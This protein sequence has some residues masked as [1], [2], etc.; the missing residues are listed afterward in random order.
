MYSGAQKCLSSPPGLSPLSFGERAME[1]LRTRDTKVASFY[2]DMLEVGKYWGSERKYHHTGSIN[3]VYA[4]REGLRV[5]HE[6]GLQ[7][8]WWDASCAA[9]FLSLFP[10]LKKSSLPFPVFLGAGIAMLPWQRLC[11]M[12][13]RSWAWSCWSKSPRIDWRH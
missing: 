8:A 3:N 5:V 2:L 10:I 9:V 4:L 12:V 7:A 1:V 11:T 6:E 13:W